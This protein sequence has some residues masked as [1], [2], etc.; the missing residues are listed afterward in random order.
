ML[1]NSL[2][3]VGTKRGRIVPS[4]GCALGGTTGERKNNSARGGKGPEIKKKKKL[5]K[6]CDLKVCDPGRIVRQ[7]F[8][9]LCVQIYAQTLVV[10][11]V[12]D[13]RHHRCTLVGLASGCFDGHHVVCDKKCWRRRTTGNR[14]ISVLAEIRKKRF[15]VNK[16]V[17]NFD[18]GRANSC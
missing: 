10:S 7:P 9:Q 11:T 13:G 5:K 15:C 8:R 16:S 12:Y 1:S 6:T 2:T 18:D 14:T 3:S 4:L 17:M